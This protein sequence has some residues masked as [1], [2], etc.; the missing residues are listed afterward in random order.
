MR[1]DTSTKILL[2]VIA[3]FLGLI[4]LRPLVQV[5]TA[6]ANPGSFDYITPLP[7]TTLQGGGLATVLMDNRTGDIWVYNLQ[8]GPRETQGVYAGTFTALGKPLTKKQ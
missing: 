4:A 8:G 7:F 3:F 5:D 6:K 2:V 1:V